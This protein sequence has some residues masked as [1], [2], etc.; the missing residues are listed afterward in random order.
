MKPQEHTNED[1]HKQTSKL[2]I[3][4]TVAWFPSQQEV[5]QNKK[6]KTGMQMRCV[7]I[8]WLQPINFAVAVIKCS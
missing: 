4:L 5:N 3:G 8:K 1:M 7:S 6:G 2:T